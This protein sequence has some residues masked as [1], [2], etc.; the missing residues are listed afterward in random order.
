MD[1]HC[2]FIEGGRMIHLFNL[3]EKNFVIDVN[4]GLIHEISDVVYDIL[5]L[6]SQLMKLDQEKL[7]NKY[8]Q[9]DVDE[10]YDA[11]KDLVDKQLLFTAS[12]DI[13]P[14]LKPVLKAM[15]L[16]V[17]HDCNLTCE[18]C[19]ASQGDYQGHRSLMSLETGKQAMDYILENSGNRTNLEVD[20]FGGEPLMNFEV[21]RELVHYGKAKEPLYN[22]HFRYTITTNGVLLDDEKMDFINT[23][24]D[25]IVLSLDGTKETNDEIR[26]TLTG[27]GS[28]DHVVPKMQAAVKKRK[29]K[30]Y[31]IR[32]TFTGKNLHFADDVAH[33]RSLGFK[34]LS[35][36]PVVTQPGD[37]LEIK[38]MD[39]DI[40]KEEYDALYK[41]YKERMDSD[42]DFSFFHFEIDL[43]QGPCLYKRIAG[44][45]AG[46]EYIAI[47]PEGHIYPCHQFIGDESFLIGT[48]SSGITNKDIQDQFYQNNVLTKE[49]C[50]QCWAKYFCSGGCHANAYHFNQD[51][52]KPYEMGCE[53]EKKRIEC[54]IR[55]KAERIERMEN[56]DH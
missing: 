8:R 22:K 38:P 47:T 19:F 21:V 10:A 16:N 7:S 48:L 14:K 53:M 55:L 46:N 49:A 24:F 26:K 13:V 56:N 5:T 37:K 45:G 18:Y 25:N 35:M 36:E 42:E 52:G 17:A 27:K 44:C 29:E 23:Y 15:C 9:Q 11:I 30:S 6:D 20:F 1:N 2:F 40:V 3:D 51:L 32:G 34:S 28:Y 33:L 39:L 54:A 31:F 50:K 12:N 43:D 4:S 41:L